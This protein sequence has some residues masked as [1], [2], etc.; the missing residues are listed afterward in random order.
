MANKN[1]SLAICQA[2]RYSR[3]AAF[4]TEFSTRVFINCSTVEYIKVDK[5]VNSFCGTGVCRG[6]R[7]THVPAEVTLFKNSIDVLNKT[8]KYHRNANYG[9]SQ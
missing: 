3:Y 2:L 9:D 8:K 6:P 7:E 1:F 4:V 5:N